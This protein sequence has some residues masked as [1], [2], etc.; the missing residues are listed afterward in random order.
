MWDAPDEAVGKLVL[1][2]LA[3]TPI[4]GLQ[5]AQV[6]VHRWPRMLPRFRPGYLPKL[7]SFLMRT[8]RSPRIAFAGDYLIGPT[9]EGALTS[10]MR[11]ASEVLRSL[12][13]AR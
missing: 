9:L 4:G 2:N 1:E 13:V 3:R 10:G 7:A 6:V 5:A 8:E 12:D 11:A